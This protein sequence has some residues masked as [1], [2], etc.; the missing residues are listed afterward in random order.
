MPEVVLDF[1]GRRGIRKAMGNGRNGLPERWS[2]ALWQVLEGVF[3]IPFQL[4]FPPLHRC[5]EDFRKPPLWSTFFWKKQGPQ[6]PSRRLLRTWKQSN[7][8]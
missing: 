6:S 7:I 2:P 1:R 4:S 8:F 3:S 5:L